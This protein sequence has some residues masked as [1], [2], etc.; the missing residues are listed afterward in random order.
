MSHSQVLKFKT[1]SMEDPRVAFYKENLGQRGGG[2]YPVF[3]GTARYQYGSGFGDILRGIW[4]VFFPIVA[5][6]ASSVLSAGADAI[7][8][9]QPIGTALKA[10]LKPAIGTMLKSAGKELVRNNF[11]PEAAPP[12]GPIPRH[13]DGTDAG[14]V[15]PNPPV[16]PP[17]PAQSG[18]GRGRKRTGGRKKSQGTQDA[19]PDRIQLL[20]LYKPASERPSYF[21][22]V[23]SKTQWKTSSSRF[24]RRR[25][26][27]R[28]IS[29]TPRCSSWASSMNLTSRSTRRRPFR[30]VCPSNSM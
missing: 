1:D 23:N 11:G 4:R 21:T 15:V 3:Q 9:N 24:S 16:A 6:G 22:Q 8:N 18:S 26:S 20:S 17:A 14:T 5:K 12:P 7:S 25:C 13:P 29:S 10:S 19:R 2:A 28:R 27:G 30:K